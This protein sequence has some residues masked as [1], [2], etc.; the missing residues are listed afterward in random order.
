LDQ[1]TWSHVGTYSGHERIVHATTSG[2]VEGGIDDLRHLRY[3][4]GVYRLPGITTQQINDL[5]AGMR[6]HIGTSYNYR[7]ALSLGL[8]LA[9]RMRL[10]GGI[11]AHTTPNMLI[12]V[13]GY[14]LRNFV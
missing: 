6:A 2:V 7:G 12:G 9:L 1:G 14:E 10:S 3:R 13:K 11:A 5:V 4:V 8:R